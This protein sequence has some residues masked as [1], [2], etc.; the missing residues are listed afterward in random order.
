M[1]QEE[2][3][4]VSQGAGEQRGFCTTP[5]PGGNEGRNTGAELLAQHSP[6]VLR[7]LCH[8]RAGSVRSQLARGEV[9]LFRPLSPSSHTPACSKFTDSDGKMDE[10]SVS[11]SPLYFGAIHHPD[12]YQ[13]ALS[14]TVWVIGIHASF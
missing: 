10:D 6:S 2:H 8:I 11:S 3:S 12:P 9:Q 13:A 5:V 7:A 14:S 1:E 4:L